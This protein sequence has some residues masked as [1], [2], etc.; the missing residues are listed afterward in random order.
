[1]TVSLDPSNTV[2][3]AKKMRPNLICLWCSHNRWGNTH[4]HTA[5]N[6]DT[7]IYIL[8]YLA[9]WKWVE[10]CHVNLKKSKSNCSM[11]GFNKDFRNNRG[12]NSILCDKFV[13]LCVRAL[14]HTGQ[15]ERKEIQPNREQ[16]KREKEKEKGKE[17][18]RA[19]QHEIYTG[20]KTI[21]IILRHSSEQRKRKAWKGDSIGCNWKL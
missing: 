18:E 14:C 13:T 11:S 16:E 10:W 21:S 9:V 6:Y 5:T 12:L 3:T 2:L 1:M 17:R 4:T 19:G 7:H 20:Q 8:L 15:E